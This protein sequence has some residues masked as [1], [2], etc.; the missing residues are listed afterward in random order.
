M[1][2]H[3]LTLFCYR[4]EVGTGHVKPVTNHA[5]HLVL[6]LLS[7][8]LWGL[9]WLCA[10]ACGSRPATCSRCGVT[11]DEPRAGETVWLVDH[12]RRMRARRAA[13]PVYRHG[14]YNPF[15]F[16]LPPSPQR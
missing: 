14:A 2:R 10:A 1:A 6:T 7:N 8:G 12:A 5:L 13:Q 3:S 11:Y 4:C 15:P 16:S 9:I